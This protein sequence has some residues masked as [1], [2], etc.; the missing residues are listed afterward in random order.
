L[1]VAALVRP[2]GSG[3]RVIAVG[4]PAVPALQA[5]VRW[6]PAGFAARELAER[7]SAHLTPVARM[8][9]VTAPPEVLTEALLAF[10]TPR[11]CEVLGPVDI[12]DETA[13]LVLRI[14]AARGPA[15]S[16][17]LQHLQAGRSSRKLPPLRIQI[18]P[19]ELT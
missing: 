19:S 12:G 14:P 16:R 9:T 7:R 4:D 8:A 6:D 17:A 13:R 10:E 11:G 18:D 5:L 15:L 1:R 3:G 2:A